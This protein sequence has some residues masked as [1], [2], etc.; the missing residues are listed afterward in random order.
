LRKE[1]EDKKEEGGREA[2]ESSRFSIKLKSP[3]I[4]GVRELSI[5][6]IAESKE[7]LKAKLPPDLK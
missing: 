3:Q 6:D 5:L 7:E 1:K 4:N 2:E